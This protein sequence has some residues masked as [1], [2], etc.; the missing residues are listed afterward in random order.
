MSGRYAACTTVDVEADFAESDKITF[1]MGEL[2]NNATWYTQHD[3]YGEATAPYFNTFKIEYDN[4]EAPT[5][6]TLTDVNNAENVITLTT[7]E[8]TTPGEK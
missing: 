1:T 6:V 5:K 8:I 7:E 3:F 2:V 4:A